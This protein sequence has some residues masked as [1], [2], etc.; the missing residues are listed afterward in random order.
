MKSE[1]RE[2]ILDF[3]KTHIKKQGYPPSVREIGKA[4]GLSS[5]STVHSHLRKL[6]LSGQIEREPD[7]TRAIRLIDDNYTSTVDVK[8]LPVLGRVAAGQPMLASQNIEETYPVPSSVLA[9]A[10]GFMLKVKGESMIDD[11]IMD[12]D[13]VIVRRQSSANNGEIVVAAIE[14]EATV[15]RI[16]VED[17]RV[18]LQPANQTMQPMYFDAVNVIG[19]VVGFV[20]CFE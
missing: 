7:L 1:K 11:G 16:Y 13:M 15:K 5:S 2:Q 14:D 10:E 8:F 6:E 20:R 9:G 17:N 18:R 19:K 12:G 3:I 4:V